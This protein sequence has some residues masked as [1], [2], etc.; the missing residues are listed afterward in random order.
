MDLGDGDL[1]GRH[2]ADAAGELDGM[3]GYDMREQADENSAE[4]PDQYQKR[5]AL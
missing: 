4:S 5:M 2:A 1:D 3:Y